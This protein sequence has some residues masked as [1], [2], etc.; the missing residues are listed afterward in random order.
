MSIKR[1]IIIEKPA[2]DIWE[3]LGNQFL[4]VENWLASIK[5]TT[6]K[7][8]GTLIAGAPVIGR[9]AHIG[10]ASGAGMAMD[11]TITKFD[12]QN[13]ILGV[14][15]TLTGGPSVSPIKGF[16]YDV[17]IRQIDSTKCEVTW[18]T[19]IKLGLLGYVLYFGI[20]KSIG[21]GFYRNLEELKAIV[22]TGKPHPRKQ[23][24]FDKLALTGDLQT[25]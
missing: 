4:P 19:K 8:Q 10:A 24:A 23:A 9:V 17:S 15:C 18:D 21:N 11:E 2:N 5:S 6:E 14:D 25:A 3:I 16:I 13:M 22:E 7:K 20:S 1:T 12:A